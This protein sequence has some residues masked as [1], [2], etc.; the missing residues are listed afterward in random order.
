MVDCWGHLALEGRLGR[1]WMTVVGQ[2]GVAMGFP[3]V[4]GVGFE[5]LLRNRRLL[6]IQHLRGRNSRGGKFHKI[7]GGGCAGLGVEA[8]EVGYVGGIS[9]NLVMINQARLDKIANWNLDEK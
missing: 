6:R 3:N 4:K 8:M 1:H 9:I 7:K 2:D 5:H